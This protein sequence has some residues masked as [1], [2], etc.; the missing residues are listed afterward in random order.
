MAAGCFAS[1]VGRCR[2]NKIITYS[3]TSHLVMPLLI[4]RLARLDKMA[5]PD[6]PNDGD[7]QSC[8]DAPPP[9]SIHRLVALHARERLLV[10]P[11]LWTD[12]QVALLG[13]RIHPCGEASSPSTSEIAGES[14]PGA[15]KASQD[16]SPA[17]QRPMYARHLS[18]RFGNFNDVIGAV[19]GLL[20]AVGHSVSD[21]DRYVINPMILPNGPT[22]TQLYV[23]SGRFS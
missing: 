3:V 21:K 17:T 16:G 14:V 18:R 15:E 8:S 13:C 23:R 2:D 12:R 7:H 11:F 5:N 20:T 4:L 22:L 1:S 6:E 10:H 19:C 9:L